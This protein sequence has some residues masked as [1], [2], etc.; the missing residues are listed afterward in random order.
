MYL[1]R[2][3]LWV[4]LKIKQVHIIAESESDIFVMIY[5]IFHKNI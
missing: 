2:L 3:H 1:V 4:L 5:V